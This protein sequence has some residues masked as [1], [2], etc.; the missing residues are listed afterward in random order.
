MLYHYSVA[1]AASQGTGP[2]SGAFAARSARGGSSTDSRKTGGCTAAERDC[3][4]RPVAS[5]RAMLQPCVFCL[6]MT[7][8]RTQPGFGFCGFPTASETRVARAALPL[9]NWTSSINWPP[10][11][12]RPAKSAA[13]P[14][15]QAST[16]CRAETVCSVVFL[17]ASVGGSTPRS[18]SSVKPP[19]DQKPSRP[20]SSPRRIPSRT[21][22]DS[23]VA[24]IGTRFDSALS[25]TSTELESLSPRVIWDSISS[26]QAWRSDFLVKLKHR[27]PG[28]LLAPEVCG[29]RTNTQKS[30]K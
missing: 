23:S 18:P 15:P 17:R 3:I 20:K 12:N 19:F 24:G 11:V 27:L 6:R 14:F 10:E 13:W 4:W 26:R 22:Y 21:C 28:G 9:A 1:R 29:S 2:L 7:V 8:M 16:I 5:T 30:A 25:G